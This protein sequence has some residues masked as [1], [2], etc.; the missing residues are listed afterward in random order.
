M[1]SL[2]STSEHVVA[3]DVPRVIECISLSEMVGLVNVVTFSGLQVI[4]A[5]RLLL[6]L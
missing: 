4:M 2:L 5:S 6:T 3:F 1:L